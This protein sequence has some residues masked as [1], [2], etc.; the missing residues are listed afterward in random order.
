MP[1]GP[2][3][4]LDR[5][6]VPVPPDG[7]FSRPPDQVTVFVANGSSVGGL[8]GKVT[9][10]L[11]LDGYQTTSPG[12]AYKASLSTIY[13]REGFLGDA[14]AV[15]ATLSLPAE[16]LPMPELINF[17]APSTADRVLAADVVLV[18]GSTDTRRLQNTD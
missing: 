1:D 3:M 9:R 17:V 2:P 7:P 13:Y 6:G 5:A 16:E 4:V 11:G 12:N 8:A 10:L 14:R 15:G 18:I